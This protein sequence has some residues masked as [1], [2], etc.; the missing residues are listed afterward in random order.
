MITSRNGATQQCDGVDS[1]SKPLKLE[2]LFNWFY[3][4]KTSFEAKAVE[5]VSLLLKPHAWYFQ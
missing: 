4:T 2:I 1:E 5:Q 3:I